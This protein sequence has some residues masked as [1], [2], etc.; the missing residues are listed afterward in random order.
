MDTDVEKPQHR[1]NQLPPSGA[2]DRPRSAP[3]PVV[4]YLPIQNLFWGLRSYNLDHSRE[5]PTNFSWPAVTPALVF[6][7][8]LPDKEKPL[9]VVPIACLRRF[10]VSCY[11][12]LALGA[13]IHWLGLIVLARRPIK[14]PILE[15]GG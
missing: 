13:Q 8:G 15:Y 2:P 11:S 7:R 1:L 6:H 12:I 14:V 10:E 3:A 4:D 9:I 5:A